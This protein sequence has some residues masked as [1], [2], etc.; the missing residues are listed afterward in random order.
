ML[1]KDRYYLMVITSTIIIFW[2][3]MYLCIYSAQLSRL[4]EARHNIDR[5]RMQI[6]D[7]QS[8]SDKFD[9]DRTALTKIAQENSFWE[10]KLPD[11]KDEISFISMLHGMATKADVHILAVEPAE[12]TDKN[13]NYEIAAVK[14]KIAGNYFQLLDFLAQ[15][16]E[17][18]RYN[19]ISKM[20]ITNS[21]DTLQAEM[22]VKIFS[23]PAA[24]I[25]K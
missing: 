6:N 9:K 19:I 18:D 3:I 11:R 14:L 13:N 7:L 15:L 20:N 12:L 4:Q 5:N 1:K 16:D 21:E 8:F 23:L 24:N 22:F 2:L 17:A 10:N 25:P